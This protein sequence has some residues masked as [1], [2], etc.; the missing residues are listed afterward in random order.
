MT[1]SWASLLAERKDY[2][3]L[4][5]L[6]PVPVL[7]LAGTSF[8]GSTLL[9]F[10]M[11]TH[12]D[13]VSIGEISPTRV[14]EGPEYRCSCGA[15][16]KDCPF[17]RQVREVMA[18]RFEVTMDPVYWDL[19]HR[20][21]PNR[22]LD[23]FLTSYTLPSRMA[24]ARDVAREW[25]SRFRKGI[26]HHARRNEAF[27]RAVLQVSGKRLFFD[28][29]KPASRIP[30]LRRVAGRGLLVIHLV[31][32]PR[33]YALSA[34]RHE[35]VPWARAARSWL[36]TN[37]AVERS[38]ASLEHHRWLRLR[39]EDLCREPARVLDRITRFA[40]LDPFPSHDEHTPPA[41][42]IIGNQMRLTADSW[43]TLRLDES[44]RRRMP[45]EARHEVWDI[46]GRLAGSY[47]Y[48]L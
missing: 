1:V 31:R 4:D 2:V 29:T 10:I 38:V 19:R 39:Y 16:L 30:L 3:S 32:D 45:P 27:I 48:Q 26:N 33:G 47:G 21:S 35:G 6:A 13:V 15:L 25:S 20:A 46:A 17:F 36:R 23:Y 41:H 18:G 37:L 9:S 40:G 43:R 22:Y 7:Y 5:P 8:C 34:N 11:N 14:A 42:H 24:R 44:W 28:A 12:P